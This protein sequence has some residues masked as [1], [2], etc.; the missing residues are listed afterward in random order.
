MFTIYQM[1]LMQENINYRLGY[2]LNNNITFNYNHELLTFIM[3]SFP[4]HFIDEPLE[5]A[6]SKYVTTWL[7][8]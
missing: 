8:F 2:V 6:K 1:S 7:I 3:Q 4:S 5:V